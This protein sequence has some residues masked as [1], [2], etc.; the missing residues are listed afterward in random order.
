MAAR[1]ATREEFLHAVGT[2]ALWWVQAACYAAP[3]VAWR[4]GLL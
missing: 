2:F 4:L 3:V 1:V